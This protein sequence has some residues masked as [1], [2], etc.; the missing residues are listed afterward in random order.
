MD[1][2][3]D[4]LWWWTPTTFSSSSV[5]GSCQNFM[6]TWRE[7]GSSLVSNLK[8]IRLRRPE[9]SASELISTTA[10]SSSSTFA[11]KQITA[12]DTNAIFSKLSGWILSKFHGDVERGWFLIGIKSQDDQTE[13]TRAICIGTAKYDCCLL[14]QYFCY[15]TN[16]GGGH[17]CHFLQA[18]W[19]DL[20]KISWRREERS[21]THWY[22]I[23]RL[24]DRGDQSNLHRNWQIRL[25]PP[26]PPV[27]L[28]WN[29]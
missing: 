11:M 21:D 1:F 3:N 20:V 8:T 2:S 9:Q 7:D 18:R 25:L 22:Q 15:E 6:G 23:S 12:T 29:K 27:L 16:Y 24:S 14:L 5:D 17:Q 13:E 26:P 28:I 19:M 10:A 4:N